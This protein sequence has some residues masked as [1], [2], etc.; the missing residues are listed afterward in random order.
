MIKPKHHIG[1]ITLQ[2]LEDNA[3]ATS[4]DKVDGDR[5][6]RSHDC[7]IHGR[8]TVAMP[9]HGKNHLFGYPPSDKAFLGGA[10]SRHIAGVDPS[11]TLQ[12]I[13]EIRWLRFELARIKDFAKAQNDRMSTREEV[14]TADDWNALYSQV[15]G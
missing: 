5:W 8:T 6:S 11:R 4:F 12:M 10:I 7:V 2:A 9:A 1:D 15:A 14:P 3:R 13:S